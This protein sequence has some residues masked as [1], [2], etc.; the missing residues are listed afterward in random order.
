MTRRQAE[1]PIAALMVADPSWLPALCRNGALLQ[2]S[3]RMHPLAPPRTQVTYL[4]TLLQMGARLAPFLGTS[5]FPDDPALA[6]KCFPDTG[7]PGALE[8]SM[9]ACVLS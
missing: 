3:M 6:G 5:C 7:N 8:Q 9:Q 2:V 4:G 1:K